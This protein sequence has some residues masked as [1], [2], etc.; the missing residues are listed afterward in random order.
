MRSLSREFLDR[1]RF[2]QEHMKTFGA[3]KEFK[4]RHE[5]YV[6]QTPQVLE[7]LKQRAVIESSE[8]SNRLEG[9]T[10][11]RERLE[12]LIQE[13]PSSRPMNRPEE[14]VAGY[15]D[16]LS[17]IHESAANMPFTV[18]VVLQLH[19]TLFRYVGAQGGQ[20][21]P[22][23]NEIVE[24]IDGKV[25]RVR[26][27]P[28]SAVETPQAMEDLAELHRQAIEAQGQEPLVAIPL[29]VLDFLCIHPF[30]DGNGRMAR[31]LT[32]LLLYQQGHQVGRYISIERIYEESK[33]SYYE[34][35]EASSRGWHEA[36]HDAFPWLT[37]FWGVLLRAYK[38]LEQRVGS[39]R[40]ARGSKTEQVRHAALQ[41]RAPFAISDIERDC[42]GI[43]REWVRQ[44]LQQMRDDGVLRLEGRGRGAR[45]VPEQPAPTID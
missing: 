9:I 28:V 18:N 4:G 27:R 6:R 26:F 3:L 40:T 1:I 25:V 2:S 11:S 35:L 33:E 14:E 23:D 32:L 30:L 41:R 17:L 20:F 29:T 39:L 34:T 45:W 24:R 7:S 5:L 10:V 8:S 15:R 16:A 21:K 31:L 12:A 36:E 44:V 37:Y 13:G 43:S 42:P 38:E 22:N 19:Q